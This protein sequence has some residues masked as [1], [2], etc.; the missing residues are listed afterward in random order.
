MIMKIRNM[1]KRKNNQ[2]GFTLIE[3]VVVMAILGIL[4]AIAVPRYQS[5]Q[6][7]AQL[8][9]HQATAR[10]VASA[11]TMAEA[12]YATATPTAPQIMEFL[13]G[14]TV[15]VGDAP[16]ADSWVVELD[17]LEINAPTGDLVTGEANPIYPID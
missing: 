11:V 8:R 13:D 6:D 17:P 4:A 15:T 16:A 12:K 10:T 1:M 14:I 3:L 5:V 2:K 9:A 7:D